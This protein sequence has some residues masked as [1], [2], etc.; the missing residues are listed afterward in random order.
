MNTQKSQQGF[1]LIE[2]MIVVAIIGILASI[3]LPAYQDY[4]KRARVSEGLSLAS[5][6]K[7]NVAEIAGN[8][9]AIAD[10]AGYKKG[11]SSP[12]ASTNVDSLDINSTTG[13]ITIDYS[14][15]VAVTGADI[16]Y[17]T[18]YSGAIG[19]GEVALPVGTSVFAAPN[20]SIKW[21][22]S[23]AGATTVAGSS[24][25]TLEAKFAPAECR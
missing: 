24:T 25:A 20:D 16:M 12:S 4:M 11:W 9:A 22:C 17:L 15:A 8:G 10:G 19:G 21:K 18:P 3:A 5:T 1:T 7:I 6:A 23:A 2:L 13:E 14:A